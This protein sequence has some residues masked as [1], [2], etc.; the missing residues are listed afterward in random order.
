MEDDPVV[1]YLKGTFLVFEPEHTM[2]LR[3][4]RIVGHL[5]GLSSGPYCISQYAASVVMINQLAT[6]KKLVPY[7]NVSLEENKSKFAL[8]FS[9]LLDKEK[10]QFI[11]HRLEELKKR[12]IPVTPKTMKEFDGR[13]MRLDIS[14][15]PNSEYSTFNSLV[16]QKEEVLSLFNPNDHKIITFRDLYARGFY[17][18]SG[19]KFGSDF[20]VYLGD[21]VRYHAEYAVRV[22]ENQNG[23]IDMSTINYRE[24]NSFQ[25]LTHTTNKILIFATVSDNSVRYWT[26]KDREYLTPECENTV[27]E[28][29]DPNLRNQNKFRK[30]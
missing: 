5:V 14:N 30:N 19:M 23:L 15:L 25:R 3:R 20:L 12:N 16:M 7:D 2:R 1:F 9:E 24:I 13:K 22:A 26:L 17:V 10:E 11:L 4:K 28:S 18:S 29:I 21:P 6:F 8:R 27:F